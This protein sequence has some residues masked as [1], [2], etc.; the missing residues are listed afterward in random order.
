MN[1]V[2]GV[3]KFVKEYKYDILLGVVAGAAGI[4]CAEIGRTQMA[5]SKDKSDLIKEI[6]RLCVSDVDDGATLAQ[7]ITWILEGTKGVYWRTTDDQ[8]TF[9]DVLSEKAL[10]FAAE[11]GLNP[12]DR[13]TG[14]LIGNKRD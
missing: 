9:A 5:I 6:D 14:F 10:E 8:L 1:V 13:I 12:N 2:N 11:R 3:V 4:A 7:H